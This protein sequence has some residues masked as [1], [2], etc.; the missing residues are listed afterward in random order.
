MDKSSQFRTI[1]PRKHLSFLDSLMN[2]LILR[3]GRV[4]GAKFAPILWIILLSLSLVGF[5]ILSHALN[6]NDVPNPRKESNG[7]VTDMANIL[8]QSTETLLNEMIS[9]LEADTGAEIAVVTVSTTAPAP[10]PKAFTTELF[11][12]WGIGKKG[13][14][15]GVLFL[16]S[17]GD[18][19]VEIETVSG[20]KQII[21]DEQVDNLINTEI[22]PQ[23]HENNWDSGVFIGT[24]ALVNLL[25]EN[26]PDTSKYNQIKIML[27]LLGMCLL[28][29]FGIFFLFGSNNPNLRNYT[30]SDDSIDDDIDDVIIKNGGDY[31][32]RDFG[33]GNSHGGSIGGDF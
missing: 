18:R 20:V 33:G 3:W 17:I 26:P 14:N 1:H 6:V 5:P 28:L 13:V 15:N 11:N 24:Q 10:S 30:N 21:S 8:S 16:T 9:Q 32:M 27:F 29:G 31:D 23:F 12:H 7:W 22:I 19:R 2:L 4:G 25:A